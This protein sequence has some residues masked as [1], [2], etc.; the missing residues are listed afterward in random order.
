MARLGAHSSLRIML[1]SK[2]A[3]LIDWNAKDAS[4]HTALTWCVRVEKDKTELEAYCDL[5]SIGM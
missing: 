5:A 2:Q 1:D 3:H 4:G